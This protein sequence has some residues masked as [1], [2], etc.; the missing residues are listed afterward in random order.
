MGKQFAQNGE[1]PEKDN[2]VGKALN[3]IIN[4]FIKI[5]IITLRKKGVYLWLEKLM[6]NLYLKCAR[7]MKM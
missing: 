5:Y 1:N 3:Y 7:L 4:K 6:N 2:T